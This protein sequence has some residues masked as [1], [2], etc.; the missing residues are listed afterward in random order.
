MLIECYQSRNQVDIQAVV[1]MD[2]T[3]ER[4]YLS[5]VV[6][7]LIVWKNRAIYYPEI[8]YWNCT[9]LDFQPHKSHCSLFSPWDDP[10]PRQI[11]DVVRIEI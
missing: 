7:D 11:P 10:E 1:M 4:D 3:L 8:V 5:L 2:F 9:P 6:I